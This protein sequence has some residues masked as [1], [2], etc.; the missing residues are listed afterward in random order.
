MM[1]L[2]SKSLRI[3][4]PIPGKPYVGLEVP[5]VTPEIVAFGNVISNP[6]FYNDKEHPLKVALGC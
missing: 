1:S 3:E 2:A 4:A 5:N 6:K